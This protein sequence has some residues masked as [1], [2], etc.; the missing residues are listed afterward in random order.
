MA[1][2]AV[3]LGAANGLINAALNGVGALAGKPCQ[4]QS[5]EAIEGG[6]RVTFLWVDNEDVEHTDTMDIMNGADGKDGKDGADGAPG[7]DGTDG[8]DGKDG[9]DYVL[10]A[11]DKAD[12]AALVLA[13]LPTAESE[14]V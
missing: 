7:K 4:I 9:E 14:V 3:T 11:Q 2:D 10:T 8:K 12:I 6:N 5:I 1:V 13:E